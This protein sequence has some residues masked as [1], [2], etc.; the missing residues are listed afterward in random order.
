MNRKYLRIIISLVFFVFLLNIRFANAEQGDRELQISGGFHFVQGDASTGT[1]Q[2]EI[3]YGYMWTDV[4]QIGVRQ[5]ASYEL[6]DPIEDVWTGSTTLFANYYFWADEPEKQLQPFLGAFLG[7]G[8]SDVDV[9]GTAGPALGAKYNLSDD[10]FLLGQYHWEKYFKDLKAGSETTDYDTSNHV[11]T[12][13]F[14][15]RW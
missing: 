2:G 11:F 3:A 6:N 1:A 13:G 10:A 7:L 9:T 14:G 4:W 8:Y 5:L 15:F 12:V